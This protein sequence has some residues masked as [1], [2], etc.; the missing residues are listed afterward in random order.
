M[1]EKLTEIITTLFVKHNYNNHKL[2]ELKS[3]VIVFL[4]KYNCKMVGD[5]EFDAFLSLLMDDEVQYVYYLLDDIKYVNCK[6]AI[7]HFKEETLTYCKNRNIKIDSSSCGVYRLNNTNIFR[8]THTIRLD[9]DHITA[10]TV[11]W[12]TPLY[13]SYGTGSNYWGT[14]TSTNTISA[15]TPSIDHARYATIYGNDFI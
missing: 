6:T 13:V 8:D 2:H 11:S 7:S 1:N 3:Q 15:C 4:G 14:I 9:C 12:D 5:G 10:G